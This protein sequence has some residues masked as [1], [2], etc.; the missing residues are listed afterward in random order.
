MLNQDIK[1]YIDHSILC[2]LATADEEGFPNVSP[3]EMFAYHGEDK[4]LIANIASPNTIRNLKVNAKV[5]VSFVEIFVQKGYKLK[6]IAKIIKPATPSFLEKVKV[7]TMKFGTAYPISS[8][9][10]I[11]ITKASPINAPSYSLFPEETEK[12]KIRKA[13]EAYRRV[14][15]DFEV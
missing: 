8:L 2:W 11:E 13:V 5:C 3:K 4:L 15:P 9:I 6:G 10:E 12:D 7:L 14:C 1:K